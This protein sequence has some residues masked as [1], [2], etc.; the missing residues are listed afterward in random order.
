MRLADSSDYTRF[1]SDGFDADIVY[2][3]PR[4]PGMITLPLGEEV[5]TPL[6]A[7]QLAIAIT[8]PASL[9]DH[10][11]IESDN[12]KVRWDAW[13]AAN[14]LSAPPPNGSRF[15]RSFLAIAAAAD[16]LRVALESLRLAE[17][18]LA[19]GRLVQPLAGRARDMRYAGHCLV[20][21]PS[22]EAFPAYV[23]LP[24]GLPTNSGYWPASNRPVACLIRRNIL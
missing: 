4:L 12:K 24:K 10:T 3:E 19:S 23:G 21:P 15:E 18:E 2:R 1:V 9:L 6:C 7:A 13:F 11:L 5:V 16:G 17:R 14:E 22:K 20:F 8:T